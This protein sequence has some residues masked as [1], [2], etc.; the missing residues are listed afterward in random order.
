MKVCRWIPT[1]ETDLLILRELK[2][3]DSDDLRKWL[4]R[5]EIYT[6][7]GRPASKGEK[8]PELLFIDPRPNVKRQP[9]PDFL[10][11]IEMKSSHE[12]IGMIEVRELYETAKSRGASDMWFHK[13]LLGLSGAPFHLIRKYM[14]D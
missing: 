1:L 2:P 7:W 3:E 14:F 8:N 4:G 11:G 9:S 12:V 13:Q 5:D 10:W 6:Y